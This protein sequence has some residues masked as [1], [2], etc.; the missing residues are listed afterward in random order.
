MV[1]PGNGQWS[2]RVLRELH[3]LPC[4]L[5]VH[6]ELDHLIGTLHFHFST[7]ATVQK[8]IRRYCQDDPELR[9]SGPS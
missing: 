9:H 5:A 7:A 6:F 8:E 3:A 4:S 2:A 1:F